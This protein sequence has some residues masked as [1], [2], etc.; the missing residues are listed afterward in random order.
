MAIASDILD[1]LPYSFK[2]RDEQDYINFLWESF[3]C[4][5][6]NAKYPFAFIAYHML[7]MSFVYFEVWQIKET[8]NCYLKAD[9]YKSL[10]D[11]LR[12]GFGSLDLRPR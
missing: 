3:E 9:G 1:Y 4:N 10:S 5:Y 11:S 6:N 8:E 7:Y 12:A 2:T